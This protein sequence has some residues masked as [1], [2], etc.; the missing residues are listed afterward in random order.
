MSTRTGC[1]QRIAHSVFVAYVFFSKNKQLISACGDAGARAYGSSLTQQ[2]KVVSGL[3]W[4]HPWKTD[5]R[6]GGARHAP[7]CPLMALS[8]TGLPRPQCGGGNKKR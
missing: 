4:N 5:G 1:S 8:A 7:G 6:C 2:L 3:D